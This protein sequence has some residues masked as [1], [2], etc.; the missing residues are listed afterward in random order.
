MYLLK[1]VKLGS[2]KFP[3]KREYPLYTYWGQE[4]FVG[5]K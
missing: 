3:L 4:I 1:I 5:N 2:L